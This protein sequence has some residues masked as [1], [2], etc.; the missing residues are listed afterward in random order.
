MF[1]QAI[2]NR[3]CCS[4]RPVLLSRSSWPT[5]YFCVSLTALRYCFQAV[6]LT[7]RWPIITA[8]YR[9]EQRNGDHPYDAAIAAERVAMRPQP[10]PLTRTFGGG[11]D[12]KTTLRSRTATL[13]RGHSANQLSCLFDAISNASLHLQQL[14]LHCQTDVMYPFDFSYLKAAIVV[15]RS[16]GQLVGIVH[17]PRP[18]PR[19]WR[20]SA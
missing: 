13:S 20:R 14:F 17:G 5:L 2:S 11:G 15:S 7:P 18:E 12:K 16:K 9:L 19:N 4:T 1:F 8:L 6:S 10:A 3:N